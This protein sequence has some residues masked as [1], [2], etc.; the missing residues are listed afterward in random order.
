M[1]S[2]RALEGLF[3][4][5]NRGEYRITSP[6]SPVYNCIAWAAGDDTAWWWPSP[7]HYWPEGTP[8]EE[9]IASFQALFEQLDYRECATAEPEPGFEKVALFVNADDLPTHAARQLPNGFWTSKL[10]HWPDI[11]HQSL[12]NL[13]GNPPMYGGVAL[14]LR[15]PH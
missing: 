6:A 1:T 14:L 13:A 4:G 15:R 10:G 2:E 3:P 12:N 9:T 8:G 11:E 5:L 7:Q